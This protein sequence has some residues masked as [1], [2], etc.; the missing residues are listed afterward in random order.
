[1]AKRKNGK[2]AVY[3]R[4]DGRWEA[5]FRLP[6]IGRWGG[7][8]TRPSSITSGASRVFDE[9]RA[10]GWPDAV[11]PN[12]HDAITVAEAGRGVGS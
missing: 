6:G 7:K 8:S 12:P 4:A 5:Q 1:M 3:H 9:V 11:K 2:G 10:A